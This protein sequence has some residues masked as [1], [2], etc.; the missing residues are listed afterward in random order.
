MV[1]KQ[2]EMSLCEWERERGE[3]AN[4][5]FTLFFCSYCWIV[6][7]WFSI[8]TLR[9]K[10]AEPINVSTNVSIAYD[11][12]SQK[13]YGNHGE[14]LTLAQLQWKHSTVQIMRNLFDF[15]IVNLLF[16]NFQGLLNGWIFDHQGFPDLIFHA[17]QKQMNHLAKSKKLLL[18]KFSK[19][20]SIWH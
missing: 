1:D 13:N 4:I 8:F 17:E 2:I 16:G 9:K 14:H 3:H 18:A 19:I 10:K 15:F 20:T 5:C 7:L 6:S 12:K 11:T